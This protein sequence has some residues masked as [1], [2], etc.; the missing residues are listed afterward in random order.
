VGRK[1]PSCLRPAGAEECIIGPF[2]INVGLGV[3]WAGGLEVVDSMF[4]AP[5]VDWAGGLGVVD[6]VLGDPVAGWSDALEAVESVSVASGVCGAAWSR[7]L[8]SVYGLLKPKREK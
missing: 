8:L 7:V 1:Q 6:S 2:L 5:V 4:D 3:G